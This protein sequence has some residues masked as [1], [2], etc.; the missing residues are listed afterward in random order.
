MKLAV[1]G[2]A[3]LTTL[4]SIQSL[5]VPIARHS[6][7]TLLCPLK[8]PHL[9]T[10]NSTFRGFGVSNRTQLYSLVA[11]WEPSDGTFVLTIIS[12]MFIHHYL[13]RSYRCLRPSVFLPPSVCFIKSLVCRSS[14]SSR[15]RFCICLN[16]YRSEYI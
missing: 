5:C 3:I 14:D 15:P 10:T 8:R 16:M 9:D 6:L 11:D 4:K 1:L 2:L 12:T 13:G 7:R